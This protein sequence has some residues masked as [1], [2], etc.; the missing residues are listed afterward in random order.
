MVEPQNILDA[1]DGIALLLDAELCVVAFGAA[2][3]RAFWHGNGGRGT[4]PDPRG[5]HLPD[6][7]PDGVARAAFR[8]ALYDVLSGARGPL[9]MPFRCDAP[10][11]RRDMV[12]TVRRCGPSHLLYHSVPVAEHWQPRLPVGHGSGARGRC[13]M[14]DRVEP[15]DR[16]PGEAIDWDDPRAPD[17]GSGHELPLRADELCPR[18]L[19]KLLGQAA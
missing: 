10:S 1:L 5:R 17:N 8:V 19:L 18:C 13:V 16:G 11:L 6:V 9:Q 3:W 14:C 4:A 12:L 15:R 2:N 7:L